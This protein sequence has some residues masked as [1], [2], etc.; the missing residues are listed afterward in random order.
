MMRLK[1]IH[2]VVCGLKIH[3][4]ILWSCPLIW[5]FNYLSIHQ[6]LG[7]FQFEAITN[8]GTVNIHIQVYVQVCFHLT[9]VNYLQLFWVVC[10]TYI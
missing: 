5:I 7:Y 1:I 9:W 3:S 4:L 6:Q 2:D 10:S 8:K